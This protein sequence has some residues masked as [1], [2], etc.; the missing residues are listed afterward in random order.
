MAHPERTRRQIEPPPLAPG[1]GAQWL[2]A[3]LVGDSVAYVATPE[4]F[5]DRQG[6]WR[7]GGFLAAG[8]QRPPPKADMIPR[9]YEARRYGARREARQCQVRFRRKT[10]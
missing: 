4:G 1:A 9:R 5:Y 7:S 10:K 8:G 2:I 3:A 6:D